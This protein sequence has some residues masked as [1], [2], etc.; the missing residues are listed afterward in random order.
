MLGGG[1]EVESASC[2][3][4]SRCCAAIGRVDT[5]RNAFALGLLEISPMGKQNI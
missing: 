5:V 2:K 3:N 1:L 4:F